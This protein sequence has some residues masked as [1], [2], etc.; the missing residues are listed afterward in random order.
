MSSPSAW[1]GCYASRNSPGASAQPVTGTWRS[2]SCSLASWRTSCVCSLTSP[3]KDAN[4]RPMLG[5]V[6][7]TPK[8]LDDYVPVIGA[9]R[10]AE[11]RKLAAPLAGARVLHLNATSFGGGGA[12]ILTTLVPPLN[13]AGLAA[14]W[15]VI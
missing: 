10:V 14:D 15:Q 11:I 8:A 7:L 4:L 12:E 9:E 5:S 6:P 1:P 13:D 2:T 3:R